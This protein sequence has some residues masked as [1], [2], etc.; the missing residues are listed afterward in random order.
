MAKI[1]KGF[2][3]FA[4]DS[5]YY[6]YVKKEK[7]NREKFISLM[8]QRDASYKDSF[9]EVYNYEHLDDNKLSTKAF[10]DNTGVPT[11]SIK[12]ID[13][14]KSENEMESSSDSSEECGDD[15]SMIDHCSSIID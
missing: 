11:P 12:E 6:E 15:S 10:I 2:Y 8:T 3:P 7:A 5:T 13:G 9:D 4:Y 14:Y 1:H